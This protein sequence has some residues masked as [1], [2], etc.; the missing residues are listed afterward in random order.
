LFAAAK[1]AEVGEDDLRRLAH[2]VLGHGLSEATGG[3][4]GIMQA[5]L[6][7]YVAPGSEGPAALIAWMEANGDPLAS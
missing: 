1:A 5:A 2:F 4:A 3:E 6:E 7:K